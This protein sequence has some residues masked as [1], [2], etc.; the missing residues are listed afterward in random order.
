LLCS[1]GLWGVV[2]EKRIVQIINSTREPQEACRK[3]IDYA[4]QSGG[5]DNITAILIRFAD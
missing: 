2:P 1:D 5:P 4:N 3:L